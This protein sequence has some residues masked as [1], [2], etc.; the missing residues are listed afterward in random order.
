[1]EE[2]KLIRSHVAEVS[3]PET[4]PTSLGYRCYH[5]ARDV[6]PDD[7]KRAVDDV[8]TW[9][10]ACEERRPE[11]HCSY[12]QCCTDSLDVAP[13]DDVSRAASLQTAPVNSWLLHGQIDRETDTDRQ[14]DR[15]RFNVPP[16]TLQAILGTGFYRSKV[17]TN[18]VKALKKDRV[19]RI[20]LLS[21]QVHPTVLQ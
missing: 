7:Q 5:D 18:S 13:S 17:P 21:H 14:I 12:C 19:L 15:A 1:M 2:Q 4:S 9:D 8:R 16:N 10:T 6:V 3:E 20:R 11:L